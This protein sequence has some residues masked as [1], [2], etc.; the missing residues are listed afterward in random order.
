MKKAKLFVDGASRGNP[1][2]AGYGFVI[3]TEDGSFEGYGYLG[4]STNNVAEYTALIEGLKK[5][6]DMGVKELEIYSDSLLVVKQIKGEYRVKKPH[7]MPLFEEA[8]KLLQNFEKVS[9]FHIER[10]RNRRADTLANLGI[11]S[12]LQEAGRSLPEEEPA[13]ESPGPTGQG[14]G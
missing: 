10:N 4:K 3:E 13:E 5:A 6:L 14:A 11:D 12:A 8:K 7:L 2:P 9:I 1:G